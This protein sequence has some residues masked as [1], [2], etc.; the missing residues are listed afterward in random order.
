MRVVPSGLIPISNNIYILHWINLI[1]ALFNLK[2]QGR[3]RAF[4]AV[5]A[6]VFG[7]ATQF[8]ALTSLLRLRDVTGEPPRAHSELDRKLALGRCGVSRTMFAIHKY[9]GRNVLPEVI[10]FS[11]L[12]REG[13]KNGNR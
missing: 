11:V 13:Q 2:A 4:T 5:A 12:K 10:S 7:R 1:C 3:T 9:E 6:E 8:P